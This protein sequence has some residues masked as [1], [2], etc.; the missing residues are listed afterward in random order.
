MMQTVR[1]WLKIFWPTSGPMVTVIIAGIIFILG[2]ICS[3]SLIALPP[4]GTSTLDPSHPLNRPFSGFMF[5]LSIF[6]FPTMAVLLVIGTLMEKRYP[7]K[8]LMACL[9]SGSLFVSMML[10]IIAFLPDPGSGLMAVIYMPLI[11]LFSIPGVYAL[12]KTPA[13]IRRLQQTMAID[14]LIE[15]LRLD[16]GEAT[17]AEI[18]TSIG[19]PVNQV[20]GLLRD[21]SSRKNITLHQEDAYERVYSTAALE[22]KL[23]QLLGRIK[24]RG[25]IRLDEL[26][27]E[28]HV[29]QELLKEWLYMLV[30]R[31]KFTGYINWNDNTI[32]STEA[33]NLGTAGRCPQCGGALGLAGK[34]IIH[35]QHCG[36]EVFLGSA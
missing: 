17:Y 33:K 34:G 1:R 19:V 27:N 32:Y 3:I 9:T 12:F 29:P 35:C 15:Y 7:A 31:N 21:V 26:A 10:A 8:A 14:N 24:A 11:I 22:K 25:Q 28:L 23:T 13:E 30:Q 5:A 36:A 16:D 4:S 20:S 18:A 6:V 2:I